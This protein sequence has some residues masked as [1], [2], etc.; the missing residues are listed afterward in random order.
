MNIADCQAGIIF[1]NRAREWHG[2]APP[3]FVHDL[4][5]TQEQ[6]DELL[7]RILDRQTVMIKKELD[8][9][10]AI[11]FDDVQARSLINLSVEKLIENQL[12]IFVIEPINIRY[13]LFSNYWRLL[14]GK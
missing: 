7:R 5:M 4:P 12:Y 11:I 14:N 13:K 3:A 8:A 9:S 10:F 6:F 2:I 1:T